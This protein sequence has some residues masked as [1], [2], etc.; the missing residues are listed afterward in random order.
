MQRG[1][2]S[3]PSAVHRGGS[4]AFQT[5]RSYHPG[6]VQV[7]LVDGSVRFINETIE[8]QTWLALLG[9]SRGQAIGQ[10]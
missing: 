4:R 2:S 10:F 5:A 8:M 9:M 6:G 7:C 3:P 1:Q